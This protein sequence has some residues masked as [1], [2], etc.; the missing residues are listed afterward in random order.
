MLLLCRLCHACKTLPA[1]VESS[2]QNRLSLPS[3]GLFVALHVRPD[4]CL[5]GN[6]SDKSLPAAAEAVPKRILDLMNV[7]GLTRE[8]VASH[9][10]VSCVCLLALHQVHPALCLGLPGARLLPPCATD[11]SMHVQEPEARPVF[12]AAQP[13]QGAAPLHCGHAALCSSSPVWLCVQ[14]YRLY[15]KRVSG[16][17]LGKDPMK[18]IKGGIDFGALMSNSVMGMGMR[19]QQA[20]PS[21][22]AVRRFTHYASTMKGTLTANGNK[23]AAMYKLQR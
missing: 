18:G 5:T 12:P 15:L 3:H 14:K 20:M 7:E 23:S 19:P 22:H 17:Q 1:A 16:V 4:G 8:N 9:L 11:A 6:S 10:Q 21:M 13:C 2:Q